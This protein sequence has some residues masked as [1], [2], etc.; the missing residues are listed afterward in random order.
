M[1]NNLPALTPVGDLTKMAEAIAKSKLF[2]MKSTEEA[3]ALMLIAQ[4]EG[5]H[6][7]IAARDY[8]VISGRPSLK[9]DAMMARF[10][11]AGGSVSWSVLTDTNA[12][13]TFSH[14]QGGTVEI[15]WDLARAAQA[16]VL[17]NAMWKKYPRQMLRARVLS[18][19]IRTVFP[20]VAVGIY[21]PEETDDFITADK[22]TGKPAAENVKAARPASQ[23]K[24]NAV[25]AQAVEVVP[26]TEAE[27]NM[28][29]DALKE[30]KSMEELSEIKETK[31]RP[32]AD[33]APPEEWQKIVK[34]SHN[35]VARITLAPHKKAQDEAKVNGTHIKPDVVDAVT[36]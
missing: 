16:Q 24:P 28:V 18:E 7:A 5:L 19:G 17:G 8:H 36:A 4:A 22:P 6:P 23:Q 34:E 26:A 3:L 20:G 33:R 15:T 30:A 32:I 25:D 21:T 13:A 12:A 35:S 14:P 29:L 31:M 9:A 27:I 10:Q 11:A 1:T 2:G